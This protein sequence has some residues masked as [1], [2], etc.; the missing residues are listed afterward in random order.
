MEKPLKVSP[1]EQPGGNNTPPHDYTK[2]IINK[3]ALNMFIGVHDFEKEQKQKVLVS[4]EATLTND[5]HW[6]ADELGN[7]LNYETLV[8]GISNIAD[9][10]HINLVETFAEEIAQLCLKDPR[11][12]TVK[13]KVEKPDIF[14]F[15]GSVAVEIL[16]NR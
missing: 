9:R 1:D 15:I 6:Q 13:V 14:A 4:V 5:G 2:I 16:R 3:M 7:T 12:N 10:A 8:N 11:V